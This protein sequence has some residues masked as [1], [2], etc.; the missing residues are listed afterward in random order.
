MVEMVA[1]AEEASMYSV[2]KY[3]ELGLFLLLED[4]GA[5]EA[6]EEELEVV[7]VFTSR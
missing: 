3:R 6:V 2:I 4:V 1:G 5:L 7:S